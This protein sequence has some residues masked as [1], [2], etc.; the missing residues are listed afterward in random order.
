[1]NGNTDWNLEFSNDLY[2]CNTG[3][4]EGF[5]TTQKKQTFQ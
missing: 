1:M 2:V 4:V 5:N 3:V